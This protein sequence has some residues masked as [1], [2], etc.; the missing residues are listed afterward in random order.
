[1]VATRRTRIGKL[2]RRRM[3]GDYLLLAPQLILY[4]GLTLLPFV[5]AITMLFTDRL[6]FQDTGVDAIGWANFARIFTDP[7]IQQEYLPALQRTLTFVGLNYLMVYVFGLSLAL[8]IY[9]IGFQG[10]FF[11]IVL[12]LIHIYAADD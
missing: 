11:T 5:V 3:L 2:Q 9:E 6:H 1:M 10:W 12:S 7:N 4:V 8:L